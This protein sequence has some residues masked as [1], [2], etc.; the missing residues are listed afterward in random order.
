MFQGLVWRIGQSVFG[1]NPARH[2]LRTA[3]M[4]MPEHQTGELLLS[5][6]IKPFFQG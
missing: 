1:L 2:K 6:F 4:M 3:L 5:V